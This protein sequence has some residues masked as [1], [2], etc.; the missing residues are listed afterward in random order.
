ML[1]CSLSSTLFHSA[2]NS[3]PI[4]CFILYPLTVK[5][6]EDS[7]RNIEGSLTSFLTI[8]SFLIVVDLNIVYMIAYVQLTSNFFLIK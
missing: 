6:V 2:L 3:K 1:K 5:I 7:E 4:H 8:L